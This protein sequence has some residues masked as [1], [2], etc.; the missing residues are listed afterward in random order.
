[1]RVVTGK[2][3][4]E[5]PYHTRLFLLP[6]EWPR[7]VEIIRFGIVRMINGATATRVSRD[8]IYNQQYSKLRRTISVKTLFNTRIVRVALIISEP[9]KD[10]HDWVRVNT[11]FTCICIVASNIRFQSRRS[12]VL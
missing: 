11:Y 10:V 1:M 4:V 12:G 9:S 2:Y 8:T 3:A 7:R 6:H 5:M